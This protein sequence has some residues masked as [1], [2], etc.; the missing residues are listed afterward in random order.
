MRSTALIG[1]VLTLASIAFAGDLKPYQTGKLLQPDSANCPAQSKSL[2]PSCRQY[3]LES[4]S[5]VFHIR[6]KNAKHAVALPVG[7][8]AQFRIDNG[9]I[10]LHMD[11]VDNKEYP[12]VVVSISPR[13]ENST[14][15]AG[16]RRLN[17]LQ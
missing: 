2:E 13:T 9:L 8:R 11:G 17:H 1:A 16:P 15:D 10:L 3:D 4:D 12:Y 6:P 14:A 7:E 5:V